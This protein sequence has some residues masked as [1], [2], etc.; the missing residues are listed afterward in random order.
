MTSRAMMMKKWHI[1]HRW[2]LQAHQKSISCNGFW[3]CWNCRW[4]SCDCL[5]CDISWE[6]RGLRWY[7]FALLKLSSEVGIDFN[8]DYLI[9]VSSDNTYNAA[10]I[11]FP[12]LTILMCYFHMMQYVLKKW[13]SLFKTE[14]AFDVFLDVIYNIH[15]S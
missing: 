1:S 7:F 4:I 5:L 9:M 13:G 12:N 10:S 11:V 2:H 3:H 8:L 6:R 14:E 15:I